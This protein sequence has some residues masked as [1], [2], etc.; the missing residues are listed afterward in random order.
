MSL[1]FIPFLILI[2]CWSVPANSNQFHE[3]VLLQNVNT[4]TFS[5]NHY[6]NGNRL[7]PIPQMKCV[8]G[9]CS[10]KQFDTVQC[11]NRGTDG[12]DVQW[13]CKANLPNG[14]DLDR[15]DVLC[16]GYESPNDP[17][18]L[19]GSCGLEYTIKKTGSV[20]IY[21]HQ[22]ESSL[23]GVGFIIM[24]VV[25]FFLCNLSTPANTGY[26]APP[27]YSN[28]GSLLTGGALGYALGRSNS[29]RGYSGYNRSSYGGSSSTHTSTGFGTTRRR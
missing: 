2:L 12:N 26:Y 15:T 23:G 1:K 11:Y 4:L 14:Y 25:L 3:K 5:R 19:K 16:E 7:S 9:Y 18:I 29:N 21:N 8:S 24:L 28:T 20:N 17:Y 13:E 10:V 6:T 27:R 22:T